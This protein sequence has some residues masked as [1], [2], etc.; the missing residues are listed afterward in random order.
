[1]SWL[2]LKVEKVMGLLATVCSSFMGT[3]ESSKWQ[4]MYGKSLKK[5]A[6]A[7]LL[8]RNILSPAEV[9]LTCSS[10]QLDLECTSPLNINLS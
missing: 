1:M 2:F 4:C 8:Q 9:I 7:K 5:W 3:E 10:K 6:T